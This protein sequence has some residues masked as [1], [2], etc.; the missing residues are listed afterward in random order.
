[1]TN[2]KKTIVTAMLVALCVVLPMA[3]HAVPQAGIMLLPMHIPV[4]LAGLVCGWKFGLITGLVAPILSSVMTGMP[5]MGI[6]PVMTIELGVYGLVAG[7]MIQFVRTKRSSVDLYIS[8]A[9]AMM[10]GRVIAG[11]AQALYFFEGTYMMSMWATLYF[12]TALP[13]L[14]IQ[15]AFIPSVVM[16]LEREKIIPLRYP[17]RA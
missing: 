7:L 13:G 6:V 2:L 17:L 14:V 5:P 11:M 16:A 4:L 8:L 1:M 12:Q 15:L 10:A 3:F 9:T